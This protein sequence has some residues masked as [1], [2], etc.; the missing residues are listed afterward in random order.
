MT[1]SPRRRHLPVISSAPV[2]VGSNVS[3]P[4]HRVALC[5]VATLVLWAPLA[6]LAQSVGRILAG[7]WEPALDLRAPDAWLG[8]A[9]ASD[10]AAMVACLIGLPITSFVLAGVVAGW[11]TA[12]KFSTMKPREAGLGVALAA[13]AIWVLA[14]VRMGI[15]YALTALVVACVVGSLSGWLGHWVGRR[16]SRAGQGGLDDPSRER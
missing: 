13:A 4:W 10:K 8:R 15:S 1:D 9:S 16:R 6:A 2:A 11:L 7:W 5:A 12:R 3:R 14:S